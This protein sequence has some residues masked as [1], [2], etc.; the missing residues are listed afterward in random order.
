MSKKTEIIISV[1]ILLIGV[2][3]S[4][5]ILWFSDRNK[6]LTEEDDPAAV[7]QYEEK[8]QY[9]VRFYDK[10]GE[11]LE[12]K[13]VF[14]GAAALPPMYI[15][16]NSIL[17]DWD[18]SLFSVSADT[19]VFPIV[20]STDEIKNAVYAHAAFAKSDEPFAV[21]VYMDGEVD[22]SAFVI[23]VDYDAAYLKYEKEKNKINGLEVSDDPEAGKVVLTY[24]DKRLTEQTALG[25]LVFSAKNDISFQ[26]TVSF[27]TKEIM[28]DKE[29]QLQYTDSTAYPVTLY[30]FE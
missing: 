18:K 19:D 23:E 8:T 1:V 16:E 4:V 11:L 5:G 26:S 14:E 21:T 3:V 17:K 28:T 30:H 13:Q 27:A 29:G 15:P 9:S 12:S 25:T 7:G 2:A 10:A 6:Q 24:H 22:C 20:V